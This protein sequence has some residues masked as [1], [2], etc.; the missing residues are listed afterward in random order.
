MSFRSKF[1]TSFAALA[2]LLCVACGPTYVQPVAYQQPQQ[3]YVPAYDPNQA[4]YDA[5]L[6]VAILNGVNGYYGPGH[7]FYPVATYGGVSGYYDSGHRF[8][9]SV[10][11]KTVIVN[12]YNNEIKSHASTSTNNASKP[13]YTTQT[14][15]GTVGRGPSSTPTPTATTKP[16]YTSTTGGSIGRGSSTPTTTPVSSKPN[17]GS[18]GGSVSRSAPSSSSPRPSYSSSSSSSGKH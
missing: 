11:N 2:I 16:N 1:I 6:T 13:N 9:T 14:G 7:V 17:Y 8:H 18:S 10:T 12:N 4:V 5:A 3:Q 15:N